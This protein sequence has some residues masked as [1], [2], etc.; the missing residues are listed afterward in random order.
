MKRTET[1]KHDFSEHDKRCDLGSGSDESGAWDRRALIRIRCPQME[2]RRRDLERKA[3]QSHNDADSQQRLKVARGKFLA[4]RGERGGAGHSVNKTDS[5][6][7]EG[8][9]SAAEEKIFQAGF[10]RA[11]VDLIDRKS[12]V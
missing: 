8:A 10:S 3:D 4:D 9:G 11:N 6:K 5:E 2:R 7:G 1:D 12:V